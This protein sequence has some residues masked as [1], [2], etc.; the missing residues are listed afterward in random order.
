MLESIS[1]DFTRSVSTSLL[2]NSELFRVPTLRHVALENSSPIVAA[3]W[4]ILTSLTLNCKTTTENEVGRILQQTKRLQKCV[5]FVHRSD[6]HYVHRIDLPFLKTLIV[7]EETRNMRGSA[8]S[9][10]GRINAP[11]LAIF[12][13]RIPYF[14]LSLWVSSK[15]RH[16]FANF[17][18]STSKQTDF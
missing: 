2:R 3:H 17:S 9:I 4:A 11:N 16:E 14:D 5:I 8:H 18:S 15:D 1:F 13:T 6:E 7:G 10:L 12:Q